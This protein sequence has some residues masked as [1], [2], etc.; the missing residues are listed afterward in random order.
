MIKNEGTP[1]PGAFNHESKDSWGNRSGENWTFGSSNRGNSLPGSD[2]GPG[3]YNPKFNLTSGR[4]FKLRGRNELKQYE[5][6]ALGPGAYSIPDG[7]TK[8][9]TKF[10]TPKENTLY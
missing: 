3:E 5:T 1:G 4:S 2:V 6:S 7:K 8:I 9:G 10:N